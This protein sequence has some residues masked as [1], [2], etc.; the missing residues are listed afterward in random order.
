MLMYN[1]MYITFMHVCAV[2]NAFHNAQMKPHS[3]FLMTVFQ[4][5]PKCFF[6]CFRFPNLLVKTKLRTMAWQSE[7]YFRAK[8]LKKSR[9]TVYSSL[10]HHTDYKLKTEKQEHSHISPNPFL[11]RVLR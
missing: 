11:A 1:F 9:D 2:L 4:R 7:K 8:S 6:Q 3:G 5:K 10:A